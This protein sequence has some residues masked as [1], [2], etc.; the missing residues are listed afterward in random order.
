MPQRQDQTVSVRLRPRITCPHCW[1]SFPP[2]DILWISAHD[3]LRGDRVAGEDEQRRFLPTRFTVEGHALDARGV[4][5]RHLACPRCHLSVARALLELQPLFISILGSPQSGKTYFL[6]AMIRQLRRTL[7]GRFSLDFHDADT[8]ANEMLNEYLRLLFHSDEDDQLVALPK[9][10]QEGD[11]YQS[12]SIDGRHVWYPKPF[13]FAIQPMEAHPGYAKRNL[14]SRAVCLYDNAGEHFL[15]GH[16]SA[17]QP[18]TKHLAL[19]EALLF[20]FDPVQHT[21]FRRACRRVADDPQLKMAHLVHHQDQVLREAAN[22]IRDYSSLGQND[23]YPHPL[24]VVVT[25][26]DIWCR[27]TQVERLDIGLVVRPVKQGLSALD[28]EALRKVSDRVRAILMK[29][30]ARDIVAAAEGF[31]SHVIYV[32][33]SAQGCSPELDKGTGALAVRPRDLN[34]MWA[35]IPMLYALSQAAPGL[36]RTGQRGSGIQQP[37]EAGSGPR[38]FKE[39]GS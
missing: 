30:D 25:K 19:S 34:P 15:P 38:L 24:I 13:V 6:A 32:P 26:F 28:L 3:D 18:G 8:L 36:V 39:T 22:R 7:H 35:E 37:R 1:H 14:Y 23:K 33:V 12:V 16:E 11:L 21:D 27:L 20:M 4:T 10:E 9:T 17:N 29:Y 2:E 31:A 5:C